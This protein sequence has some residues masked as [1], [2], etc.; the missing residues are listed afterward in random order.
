ML[1]KIKKGSVGLQ[2]DNA[3]RSRP[4]ARHYSISV[5]FMA[6][7]GLLFWQTRTQIQWLF[8]TRNEQIAGKF[9]FFTVS[10]NDCYYYT[11]LFLLSWLIRRTAIQEEIIIIIIAIIAIL[12]LLM[13]FCKVVQ[14]ERKLEEESLIDLQP[15]PF[16]S[17]LDAVLTVSPKRQYRGIVIPT[18]PAT[19]GPKS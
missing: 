4:D 6:I 17:I 14:D 3:R 5:P 18:T 13:M 7:V 2:T 19:T 10:S 16:D 12:Q 11:F 8:L 9:P 1:D 15:S